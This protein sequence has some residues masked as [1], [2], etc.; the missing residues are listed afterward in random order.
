MDH[1]SPQRFDQFRCHRLYIERGQHR[2]IAYRVTMY[3]PNKWSLN[4][5]GALWLEGPEWTAN[6]IESAFLIV[7]GRSNHCDAN[8]RN[9]TENTIGWDN[10]P[11]DAVWIHTELPLLTFTRSSR[12]HGS[13]FT[14]TYS[15]TFESA[16]RWQYALVMEPQTRKW[17]LWTQQR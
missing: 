3:S 16:M 15:W 4:G 1:S 14:D 7:K 2:N 8:W 11:L 9:F 17:T 5:N 10:R 12:G 13:R 6:D